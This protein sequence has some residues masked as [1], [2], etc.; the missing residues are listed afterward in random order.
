M[1]SRKLQSI[2]LIGATMALQATELK[3]DISGIAVKKG[4]NIT[5]LLYANENGYPKVHKEAKFRKTKKVSSK[6]VIFI[7][8]I[9]SDIKEVAVKAHHDI[10]CDGKVTKNW[11]GI[12]PKDG[13]GFS[14]GQTV[15]LTGLPSYRKSKLTKNDFDKT[16]K[17]KI[18]YYSN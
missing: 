8:D 18:V 3:L 10:D 17:I 5:V 13:L 15:S 4:G 9:P 7:F 14:K 1:L 6:N 16:Q 11:T 2:L 12:I